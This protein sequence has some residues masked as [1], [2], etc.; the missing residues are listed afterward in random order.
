MAARVTTDS[1][2]NDFQEPTEIM[3]NKRIARDVFLRR[4][5]LERSYRPAALFRNPGWIF[6]DYLKLAV[7]HHLRTRP[8][9]AFLQVGAFDGVSN[10]PIHPLVQAFGLRGI[11][12]EPQTQA[13]EALKKR[14]ADHPQ[15]VLVNAAVADANGSRDFY[16]ADSGPIQQ[17][18]FDKAHLLKH[19]IPADRIVSQK[20]RCVTITSLLEEHGFDR[21]DLVQIDAEGYD[22]EIVRTIDFGHVTPRIIRFEHAH[23]KDDDCDA[24]VGMLA[25]HGY[26][27]MTERRDI[28][29]IMEN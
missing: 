2:A 11:I 5:K 12:V 3:I 27:F 21:L 24:C 13:F 20:V 7:A 23:L 9:F 19:R 29:A 4:M 28:I 22:A 14:Y 18:S 8:D 15:V 26:R 10:D 17:A 25:S 16:T 6:D 1:E